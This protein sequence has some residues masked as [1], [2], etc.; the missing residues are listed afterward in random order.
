MLLPNSVLAHYGYLDEAQRREK[1]SNRN[2]RLLVKDIEEWGKNGRKLSY[3][4]GIRDLNNIAK[5]MC[6][7]GPFGRGSREHKLLEGAIQ[8][9]H[10]HFAH[11]HDRFYEL[12]FGMYQEALRLLGE[13]GIPVEGR[14]TPP[15]SVAFALKGSVGGQVNPDIEPSVIW[16]IDQVEYQEFAARQ[17][18]G[19][20]ATLKVAPPPQ[21]PDRDW[22]T[23]ELPSH[24]RSR[25]ATT[26][27]GPNSCCSG[28]MPLA[29]EGCLPS[30]Q[31][32]QGSP[33][34]QFPPTAFRIAGPR[35]LR[36][37]YPEDA[38]W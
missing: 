19:L 36:N 6:N 10:K 11:T 26:R 18:A 27:T 12:C 3:I 21:F 9:F 16:F 32:D 33:E 34:K 37:C 7:M 28:T 2:M 1:C 31:V 13:R 20:A 24:D 30:E 22:E 5:W 4:L 23:E 17:H 38:V 35:L 25:S 29:R 14:A 15:F 8:V